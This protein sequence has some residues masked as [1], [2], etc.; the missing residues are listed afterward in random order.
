VKAR[1]SRG[2]RAALGGDM[3]QRILGRVLELV[4]HSVEGM[5]ERL[6]RRA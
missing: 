4:V 6:I 3:K 5:R 2:T 1:K